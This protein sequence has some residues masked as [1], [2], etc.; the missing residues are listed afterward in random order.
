MRNPSS[1]P[2]T[3]W[4]AFS[5]YACIMMAY[6]PSLLPIPALPMIQESLKASTAAAQFTV[7][8]FFITFSLSGLMMG[9][10]TD[11]MPYRRL[12]FRGFIIAALGTFLILWLPTIETFILGRG[13]QAIGLSALHVVSKTTL[14]QDPYPNMP[15]A[16]GKIIA[17][18]GAAF[19]LSPL[20]GGWLTLY[21]PWQ[22]LFLILFVALL[23]LGILCYF[24]FPEKQTITH[25]Y[26]QPSLFYGIFLTFKRPTF[27]VMV[28]ISTISSLFPQIT[29]MILP[30]SIPLLYGGLPTHT[31]WLLST[32]AGGY[33]MGGLLCS[34][35]LKRYSPL[36][37]LICSVS[38]TL[39]LGGLITLMA[40]T[41][42]HTFVGF[43][44]IL[45]VVGVALG[46][47]ESTSQSF[48]LEVINPSLR[49]IAVAWISLLPGV[50]TAGSTSALSVFAFNTH[51]PIGITCLISSASSLLILWAW[52]IYYKRPHHS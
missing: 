41:L 34:Q 7:P 52:S 38:I 9:Y 37:L 45:F 32:L 46:L 25:S 24:A 1:K 29:V 39:M 21:A 5:A 16:L 33:M 22:I 28:L 50:I 19:L 13:L 15:R 47:I 18:Q 20:I 36:S 44:L 4:G 8:L 27:S 23:C 49:G 6:F 51:F 40:V 26:P 48:A 14:V 3:R 10:F 17:I 43:T 31:G 12:L 11:R 2:F 42:W 35:L 30:F